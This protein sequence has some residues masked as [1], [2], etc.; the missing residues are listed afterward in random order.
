MG[1]ENELNRKHRLAHE[2]SPLST[3]E[4]GGDLHGEEGRPAARA[5][6]RKDGSA[7]SCGDGDGEDGVVAVTVEDLAPTWLAGLE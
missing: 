1:D 5:T 3:S 7:E 6:A 2:A 4:R